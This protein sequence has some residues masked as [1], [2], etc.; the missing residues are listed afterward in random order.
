MPWTKGWFGM[1]STET[2]IGT[3]VL[4]D[5]QGHIVKS[6]FYV[7]D[8]RKMKKRGG[9]PR[10]PNSCAVHLPSNSTATDQNNNPALQANLVGIDREYCIAVLKLE[11][12]TSIA[13]PSPMEIAKSSE[14]R[15]GQ[16]LLNIAHN[17]KLG[18]RILTTNSGLQGDYH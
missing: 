9:S 4:W 8:L 15:I 5:D 11:S 10:P 2:I 7:L 1:G 12:L 6:C 14:L 17:S 16:P 3:G 18:G 13:L